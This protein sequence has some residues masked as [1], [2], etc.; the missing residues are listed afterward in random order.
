MAIKCARCGQVLPRDNARFCN[1]CG[2][3]TFSE[4]DT[5]FPD[6]SPVFSEDSVEDLPTAHMEA[7]IPEPPVQKPIGTPGRTMKRAPTVW[8][9]HLSDVTQLSTSRLESQRQREPVDPLKQQG[10]PM[11][12]RGVV[13]QKPPVTP[14]M[15]PINRTPRPRPPFQTMADQSAMGTM[16]RPLQEGRQAS[17]VPQSPMP[18]SIV[19]KPV[20][21]QAMGRKRL[22]LVVALLVVLI[23]GGIVAWIVTFKP[24]AVASITQPWQQ[25]CD[26][27]LGLSGQYPTGWTKQV[28]QNQDVHFSDGTDQFGI[29]SVATNGQDAATYVRKEASQLGI[30]GLKPGTLVS[31]AG[32]TWQQAQGSLLQSQTG[33]TYSETLFVTVHGNRFFT[34]MQIAPP[35]TYNE[36]D[37]AIFSGMR[38]ALHFSNSCP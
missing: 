7:N 38:S 35:S 14:Q 22:L 28:H 5:I 21:R 11:P 36:E 4:E 13:F 33:V 37:A 12:P 15:G 6:E 30:T 17:L 29:V 32:A 1:R 23:A 3:P 26:S 9:S 27:G 19:T 18:V 31:F 16:N 34:I 24:F 25:F 2:A 10:Q 20:S 8:D